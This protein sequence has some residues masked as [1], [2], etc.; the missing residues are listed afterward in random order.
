MIVDPSLLWI[1]C[2]IVLLGFSAV[3]LTSQTK[4]IKQKHFFEE[5]FLFVY[6]LQ[7]LQR[8]P[9]CFFWFVDLCTPTSK[10]TIEMDSSWRT[11]MASVCLLIATKL[12]SVEARKY[13]G[14]FL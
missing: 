13:P 1:D 8:V 5:E 3:K 9:V 11:V 2:F 4:V 14:L 10:T 7:I 6:F 12:S